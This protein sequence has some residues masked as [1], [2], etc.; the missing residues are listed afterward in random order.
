MKSYV[1]SCKPCQLFANI[2]NVNP[3]SRSVPTLNLFEQFSIDYVG[4]FP[5]SLRGNKY[6]LVAVENF[7]RWPVA[8]AYPR[9]DAVTTAL[10]LYEHIFTQFGPPSHLLSDNGSHFLND[11]VNEFLTIVKTH[12]KYSSPYRP[13]TNGQCEKM[14]GVLV[15]SIK[16]LSIEQPMEWDTHL[17]AVLYAYRTKAH[18]VVKISPFELLYGQYPRSSRQDIL[19]TF[20]QSFAFERLFKLMDGNI[21]NEES[22]ANDYPI[23]DL[24]EADILEPGTKVIRVRQ[25]KSGKLDS[26]YDPEVF[27]VLGGL[28][29]GAYQLVDARGVPLARRVNRASLKRLLSRLFRKGSFL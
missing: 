6:V 15:S 18:E 11:I 9:A 12:H 16:K 28:G 5:L 29:N 22:V 10:F 23:R 14:N 27:T 3:P 7:S 1:G 4:P 13:F 2:Q 17:P 20:G 21:H 19:Q 8:M 26:N 25:K 24:V